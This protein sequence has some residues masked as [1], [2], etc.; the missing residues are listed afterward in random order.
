MQTGTPYVMKRDYLFDIDGNN[1]FRQTSPPWGTLNAIDLSTGNNKWQVPLG[2][3]ADTVQYPDAKKWGSISFGG[4]IVTAG[5]L[6]FVAGTRD[7]YFRAFQSETGNLLWETLLPA[8][9]QATPMT[10]SINGK[11]FVVIAAGGHGKFLTKMGDHVVAY[12]PVSY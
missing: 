1:W 2:F 7:G 4:A 12:T 5:N 3:M 10:Y 9:G 6:V 8:G 11:Q